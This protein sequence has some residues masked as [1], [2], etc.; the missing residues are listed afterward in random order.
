[1]SKQSIFPWEN[2]GLIA[3][4]VS[5]LHPISKAALH[6]YVYLLQE[7]YG[8]NCGYQFDFSLSGPYSSNVELD[9]SLVASWDAV[10]LKPVDSYL[11][12]YCIFPGKNNQSVRDRVREFLTEHEKAIN[13]LISR[14]GQM[15]TRDLKQLSML[16]REAE[17][18]S[19]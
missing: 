18:S 14:F 11:G 9:L 5:R 7:L 10:R 17:N 13:N 3:E 8:V 6:N 19:Q 4:I 15:A 12:G 1:M 2:Y 16:V